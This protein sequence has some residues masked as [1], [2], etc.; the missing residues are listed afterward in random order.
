MVTAVILAV[1][2]ATEKVNRMAVSEAT[3]E[4]GM[5]PDLDYFG[6]ESLNP[7]KREFRS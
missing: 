4:T 2:L 7:E 6:T 3:S 5:F 1:I